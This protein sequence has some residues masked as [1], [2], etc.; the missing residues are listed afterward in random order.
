M[1]CLW[2][3]RPAD[4]KAKQKYKKVRGGWEWMLEAHEEVSFDS[5]KELYILKNGGKNK[6]GEVLQAH[7]EVL[8]EKEN[9]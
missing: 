5:E 8:F 9:E 1:F 3:E 4:L 7:E 2:A 6:V